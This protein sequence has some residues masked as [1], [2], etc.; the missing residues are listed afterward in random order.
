MIAKGPSKM[1]YVTRKDFTDYWL[2]VL[3]YNGIFGVKNW[4]DFSHIASVAE[5]I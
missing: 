2:E 3:W 5:R 1:L 4:H